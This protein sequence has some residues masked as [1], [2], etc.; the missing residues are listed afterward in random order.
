MSTTNRPGSDTSW[1]RRA[2]LAPIGFLVTWQT[3]ICLALSICSM[4]GRSAAALPLARRCPRRRTARRPGRARRSSACRCRRRPP[5]CRAARSGP[6]RGRCCR[7]SGRRR[8][9]PADVVLDQ[10]AALEHGD[11]GQL[12]PHVDAH[13][14]ATDGATVAL[15]APPPLEHVR[16]ERHR[17]GDVGLGLGARGPAG[18]AAA[19]VAPGGRAVG[20][21]AAGALDLGRADVGRGGR[22]RRGTAVA[23]LGLAHEGPIRHLDVLDAPLDGPVRQLLGQLAAR[24]LPPRTA[25][26][27]DLA[28]VHLDRAAVHLDLTALDLAAVRLDL[29]AGVPSVAALDLTPASPASALAAS[30]A[31]TVRLPRGRRAA[32]AGSPATGLAP[33]PP[34]PARPAAAGSAGFVSAEAS[35]SSASSAGSSSPSSSSSSPS[36]PSAPPGRRRPRPPRDPRRRRRAAD[37]PARLGPSSSAGPSGV[38]ARSASGAAPASTA[39]C[40]GS[41]DVRSTEWSWSVMEGLPSHAHAPR[42]CGWDVAGTGSGSRRAPSRSIH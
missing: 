14:V 1:V 28:A 5:P 23:D 32:G 20:S 7:G 25:L 15:P 21:L 37:E 10:A 24:D 41:G 4:R 12:G 6:D 38:R 34:D 2:P 11:L 39:R 40:G 36:A 19:L 13:Q 18:L 30:A 31:S 8:P 29:T 26:R 22:R 33:V 16:V 3:M 35:A 17:P 27:L 9:G 42:A